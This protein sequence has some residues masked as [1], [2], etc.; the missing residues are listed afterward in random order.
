[1]KTQQ[2]FIG[3]VI[4]LL[5]AVAIGFGG[6]Y[7]YLK[8]DMPSLPGF[9]LKISNSTS[10]PSDFSASTTYSIPGTDPVS[11]EVGPLTAVPSQSNSVG[12]SVIAYN[13]STTVLMVLPAT[14]SVPAPLSAIQGIEGPTTI[15]SQ[16]TSSDNQ[17]IIYTLATR[18]L[19]YK[20]GENQTTY[21]G[22]FTATFKYDVKTGAVEPLFNGYELSAPYAFVKAIGPGNNRVMFTLSECNECDAGFSDNVIMN[23][24]LSEPAPV[25][26]KKLGKIVNFAFTGTTTYRYA[27]A[28]IDPA[29]ESESP[30]YK[31]G[32]IRTGQF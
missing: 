27:E 30:C 21:G 24:D 5:I 9:D 32:R 8:K 4:F 6:T 18:I 2:G 1:M 16:A 13:A 19:Y 12:K 3:I 22:Q 17:L 20:P 11:P 14:S 28:V 31:P 7:W 15:I 26:F 23:I 29:C 25:R 10:T